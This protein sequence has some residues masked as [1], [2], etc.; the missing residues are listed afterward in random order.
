MHD[1]LPWHSVVTSAYVPCTLD[2]EP[3]E[4]LNDQL[5][6][7]AAAAATAAAWQQ[8]GIRSPGSK[9]QKSSQVMYGTLFRKIVFTPDF[10]RV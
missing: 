8:G 3:K 1:F 7:R 4:R 5:I 6:K 9:K 10:Q 2:V